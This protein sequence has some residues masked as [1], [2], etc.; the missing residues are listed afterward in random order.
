MMQNK[1]ETE[2]ETTV[3]REQVSY[4]AISKIIKKLA[5]SLCPIKD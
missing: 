3:A 1:E 4:E 5:T 2:K